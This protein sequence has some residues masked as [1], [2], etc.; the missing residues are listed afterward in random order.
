MPETPF[1][2]AQDGGRR[3]AEASVEMLNGLKS[4]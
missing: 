1:R 2:L 3:I 4:E